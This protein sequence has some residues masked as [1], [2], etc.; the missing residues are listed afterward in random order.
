LNATRYWP[1]AAG[2]T[3][4]GFVAA[5]KPHGYATV[6]PF[7][8][9]A[10]AAE[11]ARFVCDVF[12]ADERIEARTVDED[13]QLLHAEVVLGDTTIIFAERKA[14]WPFTPALLQ[15]WVDDV[16]GTLDAARSH[17]AVVVTEPTDFYGDTFSRFVD[18]WRNLWWVYRHDE[19]DE[20]ARA[21]AEAALHREPPELTYIHKTLLTT[22]DELQDPHQ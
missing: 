15:I 20:H 17:G 7:V 5:V 21:Q 22:L 1:D 12:G 18:P 11:A 13:G 19:A 16:H 6:N 9:T 10:N 8:I 4:V 2:R 3:I 14:G